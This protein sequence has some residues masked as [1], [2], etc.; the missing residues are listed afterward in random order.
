MRPHTESTS[1]DVSLQS[2]R[3]TRN[4][5]LPATVHLFQALVG[6]RAIK[7]VL[8]CMHA[9][10]PDMFGCICLGSSQGLLSKCLG[11]GGIVDTLLKLMHQIN[12]SCAC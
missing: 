8:D 3:S 6:P 4:T 1:G 12:L 11:L 9:K 2:T 7:C 10:L 5:G